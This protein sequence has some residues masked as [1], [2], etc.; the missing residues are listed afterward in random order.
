MRAIMELDESNDF[1][2]LLELMNNNGVFRSNLIRPTA[3]PL[4]PE[5]N[6]QFRLDDDL[7]SNN[8]N[9]YIMNGEEV[10]IYDDKLVFKKGVKLSP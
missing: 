8:W 9:D 4:V 2:K 6:S 10:T 3:K 5:N 7:G 1:I